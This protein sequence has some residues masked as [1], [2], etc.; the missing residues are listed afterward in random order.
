MSWP[1]LV[2][3]TRNLCN[4]SSSK[5][6][7]ENKEI[8]YMNCLSTR[9]EAL[10]WLCDEGDR[11]FL[12]F[13]HKQW[14]SIP[15]KMNCRK[16]KLNYCLSALLSQVMLSL[17]LTSIAALCLGSTKIV[18]KHRCC[19]GVFIFQQCCAISTSDTQAVLNIF[20]TINMINQVWLLRKC[21]GKHR[22]K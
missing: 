13:Q 10:H 19:G 9:L 3:Q 15:S 14:I 20:L 18:D 5:K 17:Q 6:D 8:N 7:V 22:L 21:Y 16:F 12:C 4:F 11:V 2:K 1:C